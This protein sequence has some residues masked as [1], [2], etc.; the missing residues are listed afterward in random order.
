MPP[1]SNPTARQ[2]R[3]GAELRKLREASGLTTEQAAAVLATNRTVITSTEAGRHGISPERVRRLACNYDCADSALVEALMR[4]AAERTRGW[5][6]DFRGILPPTFLDISELEWFA[7]RLRMSTMTHIPGPFQTEAFARALFAAAIPAL[8]ADEFDARL[9]HRLQRRRALDRPDAPPYV[10]IIHEAALRIEVGGRETLREQLHSTLEMADRDNV[11]V[12]V[13]PFSAGAFPG[14]GQSI[15]YAEG[16]VPSLDVV[17]L[18]RTTVAEFL[19]VEAQLRKFSLQLDQMQRVAL[20]PEQ[21]RDLIHA[22]AR[23]L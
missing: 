10:A 12:Q 18:D 17:Q 23:E 15:L 19:H 9:A 5:W 6:E 14:S 4:M 3:L 21:T 11:T 1:R 13:I 20:S 7:K 16:D 22:I 2:Q 8:P